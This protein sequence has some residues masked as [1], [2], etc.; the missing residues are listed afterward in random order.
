MPFVG[1][2]S[3]G[4]IALLIGTAILAFGNAFASPGLTSLA[5]KTADEHEQGAAMGILQSGASLARVIGPVSGGLLLN[6][7][8]NAIDDHTLLRTFWTASAIM[9][10]AFL[11]AIYFARTAKIRDHVAAGELTYGPLLA[12]SGRRWENHPESRALH[13]QALSLD[14]AAVF[15][16]DPVCHRKA[17]SGAVADA[18]GREKRIEDS[19][20]DSLAGCLRRYRSLR[21]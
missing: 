14:R 6:N 18:F 19:S 11:V 8:V 9:F 3:G 17:K 13:L 15:L 12:R 10:V 2:E 1:P 21:Q 5:S 16:D 7:A 4:L 20:S